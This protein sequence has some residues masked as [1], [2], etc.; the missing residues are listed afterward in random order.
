MNAVSAATPLLLTPLKC[1]ATTDRQKCTFP[2]A[3]HTYAVEGAFTCTFQPT[4]KIVGGFHSRLPDLVDTLP[5]L[6][7]VLV[8]AKPY[9]HTITADHT[10]RLHELEACGEDTTCTAAALSQIFGL[11][12]PPNETEGAENALALAKMASCVTIEPGDNGSGSALRLDCHCLSPTDAAAAAASSVAAQLPF[13]NGLK[14]QLDH[15]DSPADIGACV[16]ASLQGLKTNKVDAALAQVTW[17]SDAACS[18]EALDELS[19]N[20]K[21]YMA[22][23]GE[24]GGCLGPFCTC[25]SSDASCACEP[26][27]DDMFA[28]SDEAASGDT[29]HTSAK[30]GCDG[31]AP[32][33][34]KS[35]QECEYAFI[36]TD[37]GAICTACAK[38]GGQITRDN[39]CSLDPPATCYKGEP[40]D[41]STTPAAN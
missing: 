37:D 10:N 6:N 29:S 40:L 21:V 31:M 13:Q 36:P 1:H 41:C 34:V 14:V 15:V 23:Q 16:K 35:C 19:K 18:N 12:V 24:E 28:P 17:H 2:C 9:L 20:S 22:I 33:P 4:Q 26:L 38:Q 8:A 39:V 7:E 11:P 25:T 27:P 5:M 30:P 32:T 3:P